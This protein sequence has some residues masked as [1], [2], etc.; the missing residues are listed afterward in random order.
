MKIKR[1]VYGVGVNDADYCVKPT[2]Q[3]KQVECKFYSTWKNMLERCYS[4]KF[5]EKNQTYKEC[6]SCS[7][8][9]LFSNFKGWM[10]KQD[11][12]GKELDKDILV[13]GNKIYSPEFCVFIKSSINNLLKTRSMERGPYKIGVTFRGKKYRAQCNNSGKIVYLGVFDSEDEAHKTYCDYKYKLISEIAAQQTEPLK[14][15]LLNYKISEY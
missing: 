14:S 8:W 5:K 7:D 1:L 9:L 12:Q 3:G 2:I 13:Q 11:W 6:T 10:E 4:D 15:A